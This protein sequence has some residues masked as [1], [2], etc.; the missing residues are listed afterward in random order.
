MNEEILICILVPLFALFIIY[1]P[2]IMVDL[3]GIEK[4]NKKGDVK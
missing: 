1:L 3:Y 4:E 2:S